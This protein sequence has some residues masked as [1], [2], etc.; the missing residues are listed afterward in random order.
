MTNE[1]YCSTRFK[2][3]EDLDA[4]LVAALRADD[5]ATRAEQAA[6]RAEAATRGYVSVEVAK[7]L[8]T[9]RQRSTG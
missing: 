6:A 9:P 1:K 8:P 5:N 7:H 3:G 2:R 4:A